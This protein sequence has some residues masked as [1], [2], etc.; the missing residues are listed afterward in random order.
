M[1]HAF[2]TLA[3]IA[4]V[5]ACA[6]TRPLPDAT[7]AVAW[8]SVADEAVP[9]I[10][11]RDP[12]GDLRETKLWIVVVDGAGFVRTTGTRWLGNI[13]RDPNVVLRIGGAA[14]LLR[15]ERVDD[16]ALIAR[17]EQAFRAK[18]GFSDRLTGWVLPGEPTVL[19]LVERPA[20]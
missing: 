4:G 15:A 18:Y 10:V 12:D 2:A 1:R 19:R 14:H 13:E 8:A 11:T 7:G 3:V 17:V 16:P 20:P 6:S 5:S 9:E